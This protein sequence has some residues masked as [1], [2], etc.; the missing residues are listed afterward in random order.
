MNYTP[1]IIEKLKPN[2]VLVYGSNQYARHDGGAARIAN[3]RFGAQ[4][5]N[6]AIGLVGQSYGIITTSFN[7]TPVTISFIKDQVKVLYGFAWLRPDLT[8]FVTK[9]GTGIAGFS[10]EK[11]ADIFE[12]FRLQQPNNIILPIEFS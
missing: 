5:E 12:T 11:I 6:G 4:Y 8:F 10:I 9:I 1:E 3:E 7:D 2:E